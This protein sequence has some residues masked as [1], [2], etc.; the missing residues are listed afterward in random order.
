[1]PGFTFPLPFLIPNL[2]A[3]YH[4]RDS[5][6]QQVHGVMTPVPVR[7]FACLPMGTSHVSI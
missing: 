7:L 4:P 2:D 1:M 3:L 5:A 6:R